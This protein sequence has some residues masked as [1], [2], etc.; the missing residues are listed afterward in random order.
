MDIVVKKL[1]GF[2]EM[3]KHGTRQGMMVCAPIPPPCACASKLS[4]RESMFSPSLQLERF[5]PPSPA[6]PTL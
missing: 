3:I 1:G 6:A 2:G 5:S 4:L